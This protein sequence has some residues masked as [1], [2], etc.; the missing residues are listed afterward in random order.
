MHVEAR[1]VHAEAGRRVVEV[2]ALAGSTCLGSALGEADHAEEAEE[3]ALRRLL[4]RLQPAQGSMLADGGAAAAPRPAGNP[5]NGGNATPSPAPPSPT[6]PAPAASDTP[7]PASAGRTAASPGPGPAGTAAARSSGPSLPLATAA[8][9]PEARPRPAAPRPR[10]LP[11]PDRDEDLPTDA[12]PPPS[13]AAPAAPQPLPSASPSP[14]LT[15]TTPHPGTPSRLDR[16]AAPEEPPA[17]PEDWSAELARLD[18][19]LRR[20]GWSREQE[21]AY[22]QRAFGHPSRS[23]LTSYADLMA[24]LTTLEGL[25]AGQDPAAVPVPL[26]RRDLLA[27]GEVLLEQ[28]GWD[29][30]RGRA[31]LAAE[32][33]ASSRRQLSDSQLLQFNMLL[34][35]AL[36]EARSGG[37]SPAPS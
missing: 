37:V 12:A 11:A 35:G 22:L 33:G 2:R 10:N 4:Q 19:A 24:Y 23:R 20:I 31:F 8:A 3:R 26:R 18:L 36:I 1:L 34:E 30:E 21:E 14:A 13:T 5:A 28:L 17:D 16:G 29:G 15:A 6:P 27:Q 7:I 9:A 32:L 25:E